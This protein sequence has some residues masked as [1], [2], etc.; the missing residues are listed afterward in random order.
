MTEPRGPD[1]ICFVIGPIGA[2]GS[3]TR[4]RSNRVLEFLIEPAADSCGYDVI[5]ADEISSPGLITD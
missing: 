3:E 4:K 1:K 2:D 5:R